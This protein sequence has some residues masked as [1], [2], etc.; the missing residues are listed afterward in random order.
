MLAFLGWEFFYYAYFWMTSGKTH[1]MT[2]LGVQVVGHDG[3]HVVPRPRVQ[4]SAI[5]S[6]KQKAGNAGDTTVRRLRR[7]P[8][9]RDDHL[10]EP[11][12]IWGTSPCDLL[13]TNENYQDL[14][15]RSVHM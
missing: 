12:H 14:S 9:L 11:G 1:G 8:L 3:S 4:R 15:S 13:R 6:R 10:P 7:G 2:L 5:V